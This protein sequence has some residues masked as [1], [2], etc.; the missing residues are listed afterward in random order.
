MRLFTR[1]W[2][3]IESSRLMRSSISFCPSSLESP[4]AS[5]S[6]MVS[7]LSLTTKPVMVWPL[8][9]RKENVSKP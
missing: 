2:G 6:V 4:L 8:V 5:L 9:V 7:A 1:P 3:I